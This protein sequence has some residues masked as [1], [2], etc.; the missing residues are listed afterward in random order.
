LNDAAAVAGRV[1]H[2]FDNV[3]M[4]VMGFAE[5]AQAELAPG[6]AAA[7]FIAELLGVAARGQE[8]TRQLHQLHSCGQSHR[9]PTRLDD[10][11]HAETFADLPEKVWVEV[12]FPED[13]PAVAVG[14]E[15]LQTI[16]MQLVRNAAEALVGGG[17]VTVSGQHQITNA[18][19]EDAF[20]SPLPA[21][22]YV[23]LTVADA[24]PGIRPELIS[25]VGREPFVTTK[26][27]RRGLGLPIVARILAAHGGGMRIESSTRG[28][29][30][31][32]YLPSADLSL[33]A[34][35]CVAAVTAPLEVVPS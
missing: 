25:R 16:V 6:S 15:P 34:T 17:P 26:P 33:P 18:P 7:S 23:E 19:I 24:G 2:D 10:V 20:P 21:G 3:L 9:V 8:I 4:G 31:H 13:L 14:A 32:A 35:A 22:S 1:A 11:C 5:L 12:D 29:A 27:R 30:I 28:T